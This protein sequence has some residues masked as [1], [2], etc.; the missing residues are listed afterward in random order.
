MADD[1]P[2]KAKTAKPR[3]RRRKP[4]SLKDAYGETAVWDCLNCKSGVS[5]RINGVLAQILKHYPE[6]YELT[7]VS[8]EGA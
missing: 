1:K 5:H 8:P 3:R 6:D 2:D 7:F 4:K